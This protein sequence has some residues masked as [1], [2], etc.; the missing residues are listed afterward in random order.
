MSSDLKSPTYWVG[1][2]FT[3]VATIIGVYLAAT[4]GFSK[5]LELEIIRADRGTYYLAESLYS[6]LDANIENV[7]VYIDNVGDN[8]YPYKEHFTGIALNTFIFDSAKFNDSTLEIEPSVLRDVSAYYFEVGT[9]IDSYYASG[10]ASPATLYKK[11]TK[12]QEK[13]LE[14]SGLQRLGAYKEALKESVESRGVDT[15]QPE[16]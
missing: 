11:L 5:A 7:Q 13:I 2:L 8:P 12:S 4:V 1:H 15:A 16:Y 6:E 10:Q 3:V 14:N 9:A